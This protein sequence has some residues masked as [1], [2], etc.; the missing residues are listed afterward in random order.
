MCGRFLC[1]LVFWFVLFSYAY[2][3]EYHIH[4]HDTEYTYTTRLS[5]R[6]VLFANI[7]D[8]SIVIVFIYLLF[9]DWFLHHRKWYMH[10]CM[11]VLIQYSYPNTLPSLCVCIRFGLRHAHIC[12]RFGIFIKYIY[13]YIVVMLHLVFSVDLHNNMFTLRHSHTI[14]GVGPE[15]FCCWCCCF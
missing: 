9:A 13:N 10:V 15:W 5:D 6:I 11:H 1:V 3:Y 12:Y 14:C 8:L 4:A 2:V 7:Y